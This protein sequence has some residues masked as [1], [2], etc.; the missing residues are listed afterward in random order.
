MVVKNPIEQERGDTEAIDLENAMVYA[1]EEAMENAQERINNFRIEQA[2]QMAEEDKQEVL[3]ELSEQV[4]SLINDAGGSLTS[5]KTE[6]ANEAISNMLKGA[7]T[8]EAVN[9]L[10]AKR[11]QEIKQ[12]LGNLIQ[13]TGG[14]LTPQN[15]RKL[16]EI[17]SGTVFLNYAEAFMSEM[18]NFLQ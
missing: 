2:E 13:T 12:Q 14:N 3:Q 1:L 10:W 7:A 18:E 15:E 6:F 5:E 17:V 8:K 9:L 16:N 4:Y 11:Q